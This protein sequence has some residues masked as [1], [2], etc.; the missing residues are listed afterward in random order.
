MSLCDAFS[1]CW[2]DVFTRYE[3][4]RFTVGMAVTGK[5]VICSIGLMVRLL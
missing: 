1:F 3:S 4:A 2:F 5:L